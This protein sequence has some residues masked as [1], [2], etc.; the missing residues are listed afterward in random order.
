MRDLKAAIAAAMLA[1]GTVAAPPAAADCVCRCVN[2]TVQALC[3]STLDVE[4]IC[5]P[6]IC[7]I[8]PPAI[9]PIDPPTLPP[10]GTTECRPEQVLN[11]AT[12][13]YEWRQVCR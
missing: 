10:I 5:A 6:A 2:G 4:P 3:S 11:P 1:A 12:N 9:R 8:V 13:R 7:P